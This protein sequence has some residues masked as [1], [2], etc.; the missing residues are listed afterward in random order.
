MEDSLSEVT[1]WA[2]P[3]VCVGGVPL[4]A[5]RAHQRDAGAAHSMRHLI[6]AQ[7]TAGLTAAASAT[8]DSS[9]VAQREVAAR[10]AVQRFWQFNSV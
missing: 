2:G 3:S 6:E 7:V 9:V 8:K 4:P 1:L 10:R 5:M